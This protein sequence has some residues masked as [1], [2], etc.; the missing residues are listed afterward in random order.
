MAEGVVLLVTLALKSLQSGLS[1]DD[2]FEELEQRLR[3]LP[4]DIRSLYKAMWSRLGEGEEIYQKDAAVYLNLILARQSLFS[5][6][7]N[8]IARVDLEV[9]LAK[10]STFG[11]RHS[12]ARE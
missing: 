1:R 3:L 12:A 9:L 6:Y 2:N 8:G 10:N 11:G 5:Y 7:I 4:K